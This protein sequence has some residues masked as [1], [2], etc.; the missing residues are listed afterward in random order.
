MYNYKCISNYA[1]MYRIWHTIK[2][3]RRKYTIRNLIITLECI[4]FAAEETKLRNVKTRPEFVDAHWA[5]SHSYP[6]RRNDGTGI[7]GE[8]PVSF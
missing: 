6:G 4:L 2:R 8:R 7:T 5:W 3:T 1:Q